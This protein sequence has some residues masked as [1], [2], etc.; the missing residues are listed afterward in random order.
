MAVRPTSMNRR[1]RGRIDRPLSLVGLIA[2]LAMVMAGPT[3]LWLAHGGVS[4]E[5]DGQ[6]VAHVG[7][8]GHS[9]SGHAHVH[10]QE[11]T[12]QPQDEEGS[13]DHSS[14]PC[15]S[16][17]GDCDTCTALGAAKP[18]GMA[19]SPDLGEL[20]FL[21]YEHSFEDIARDAR[22]IGRRH[23]RGPPARA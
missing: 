23:S 6:Q 2:I 7:C 4:V 1:F 8:Q 16:P 21:E 11:H 15:E 5:A 20:R 12:V 22:P 13:K 3:H 9:C 18:I 17:A 10:G 19:S 14:A